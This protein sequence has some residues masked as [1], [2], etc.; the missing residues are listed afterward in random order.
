MRLSE[1]IRKG[2]EGTNRA[3]EYL[4]RADGSVCSMGAACLALGIEMGALQQES[5]ELQTAFPFL[6][7][8]YAKCPCNDPVCFWSRKGGD[9]EAVIISLNDTHGWTREAI[10]D[11]VESIE[12]QEG[13]RL[14]T[15]ETR[16]ERVLETE[17]QHH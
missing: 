1:A 12:N 6:K 8:T 16:E 10:A 2:C 11:R 3:T 13:A 15:P 17:M 9:V 4:I 5:R 7:N 14:S